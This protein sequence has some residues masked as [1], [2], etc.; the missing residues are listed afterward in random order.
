MFLTL[1]I[2]IILIVIAAVKSII[3]E[4]KVELIKFLI[5]LSKYLRL[6]LAIKQ[7]FWNILWLNLK[8]IFHKIILMCFFIF[9]LRI[10]ISYFV[11]M[12]RAFINFEFM[13][14]VILNVFFRQW[15]RIKYTGLKHWLIKALR[16]AF[17]VHWS[18]ASLGTTFLCLRRTCPWIDQFCTFDK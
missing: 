12:F 9:I 8:K 16:H 14:N 13:I 11:E 4:F 10:L 7:L 5:L 17:R 3:W 18:P 6:L 1:W 15:I 2:N